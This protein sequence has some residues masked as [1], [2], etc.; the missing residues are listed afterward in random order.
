MLLDKVKDWG[1]LVLF[2]FIII[3]LPIS[4]GVYLHDSYY[5]TKIVEITPTKGED[6]VRSWTYSCKIS[7]EH[8]T[9]G[10]MYELCDRLE[11]NKSYLFE[12]VGWDTKGFSIICYNFV[13]EE[14]PKPID[15]GMTVGLIF[16]SS[17]SLFALSMKIEPL[18]T[19][20]Q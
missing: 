14:N 4:F 7:D 18:F 3:G 5:Q 19:K 13:D 10:I 9:V 17:L 6:H 1:S 15:Y 8:Q 16:I 20:T 12:C 2:L 11:L